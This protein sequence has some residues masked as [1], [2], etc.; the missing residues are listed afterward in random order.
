M[1]KTAWI[2]ILAI[3]LPVTAA[4]L[5]ARRMAHSLV[6]SL[7]NTKTIGVAP[8]EYTQLLNGADSGYLD[9][10]KTTLFKYRDPISLFRYKNEYEI[11]ETRLQLPDTGRLADEIEIIH[12]SLPSNGFDFYQAID[13]GWIQVDFGILERPDTTFRKICLRI[14]GSGFESPLRSDTVLSYYQIGRASCRERV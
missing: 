7:E 5:V 6:Y 9:F 3:G 4:I 1:S 10:R 12:S 11:L 13:L 8:D 14:D 2:L